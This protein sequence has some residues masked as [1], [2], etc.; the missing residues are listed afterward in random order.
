VPDEDK[1]LACP[2]IHAEE[3]AV[4]LAERLGIIKLLRG[5]TLYTTLAPCCR[6][7]ERLFQAGVS[8]VYYELAY[9]SV[10]T[11]RDQAWLAQAKEKFEVFEPVL[12][13]GPS[14][15]KIASAL[16]NTTSQRLLASG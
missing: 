4:A 3:N 10:N 8:R 7:T 14:L 12:I 15:Q 9:E 5:S 6:C 13:S 11:L 2:S 1:H 16:V